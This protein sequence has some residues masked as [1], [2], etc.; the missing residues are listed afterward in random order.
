MELKNENQLEEEEQMSLDKLKNNQSNLND[1]DLDT[2]I[3]NMGLSPYFTMVI[4]FCLLICFADGS[5]MV[6]VSLVIRKL[7][8]KWNLK[9]LDKALIGSSIFYGFLIGSFFSGNIMNSKGRK[10]TMILGSLIVLIFGVASSFAIEV[11]SF[12]IFRT[13]VGFGLGLIIPTT[14]TFLTELAPQKLRGTI[15]ILIWLGFPLGEM[16]VCYISHLF[17]LDINHAS[18]WKKI[19]NLAAL[20]VNYIYLFSFRFYSIFLFFIS[21][22]K[23]LDIILLKIISMKHLEF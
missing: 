9:S 15:S 12:F 23:V 4:I 7:E 20:P 3:N 1:N 5:E 10:Y 18:N 6:V 13:G 17:P 8:T 21:L 2:I 14:Q 16:Y 19:M 11:Y 22:K